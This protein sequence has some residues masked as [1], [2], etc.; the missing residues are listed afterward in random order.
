MCHALVTAATVL[1]PQHIT[2]G[3]IMEKHAEV[4]LPEAAINGCDQ[5]KWTSM[6]SYHWNGIN[7]QKI[8]SC[9]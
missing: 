5:H 4:D 2:A 3:R 9:T 6:G 8:T 7:L 1:K